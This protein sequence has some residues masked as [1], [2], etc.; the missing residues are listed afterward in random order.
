MILQDW[1]DFAYRWG[2]EFEQHV[3]L[4]D[5]VGDTEGVMRTEDGPMPLLQ[6]VLANAIKNNH[7]TQQVVQ[8]C[9]FCATEFGTDNA[10]IDSSMLDVLQLSVCQCVPGVTYTRFCATSLG[11][12]RVQH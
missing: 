6:V 8:F 3:C 2:V 11:R 12:G 9:F 4:A 10:T 5:C 1:V 7:V